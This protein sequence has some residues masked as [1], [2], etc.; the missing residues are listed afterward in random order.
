MIALARFILRGPS[1]AALVV[2]TTA[3]LAIILMPF[4]WI[5]AGVLTLVVL[6]LGK[7]AAFKIMA[8]AGPATLVLGWVA[9]GTPTLAVINILFLWLPVVLI[10]YILRQTVSLVISMQ[11]LTVIGLLAVMVIYLMFPEMGQTF[12]QQFQQLLAPAIQ[13]SGSQIDQQQLDN[14]LYWFARAVPGLLSVV[15]VLNVLMGLFIGRWWQAALFNPGGFTTEFNEL[16]LGKSFA[17]V[18][19]LLLIANM[20]VDN[21]GILGAMLVM[22]TIV[23]VQGVAVMHGAIAVKQLSR[24]WLFGFYVLLILIPQVTVIV[25]IVGLLDAWVDIRKQIAPGPVN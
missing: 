3:L 22:V 1:Q 25:A 10:A 17:L 16:R 19:A 13:Q 15:M 21:D 7:Q 2:T 18:A 6:H 14:L 8:I 24:S 23:L 12:S 20:L 9:L 5:S 11:I 4:S